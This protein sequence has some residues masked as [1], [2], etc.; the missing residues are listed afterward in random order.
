MFADAFYGCSKLTTIEGPLYSGTL[1]P[2]EGM[3]SRTFYNTQIT[4]VPA[5]VFGNLKGDGAPYMFADAFYGCSKLTTIEGPLYSGTLT[6]AES[7][8]YGTFRDSGITSVP[9]NVFG[10]LTGDGA[11]KMFRNT[12]DGCSKLTTIE[13][14]LFAGT[15]TPAEEM[16][17]Y[18]FIYT[19]ITSIPDGLFDGIVGAPAVRMFA[20]T[21]EDTPITSIPDG[22]FAGISG[23]PAEDMFS[24]TFQDTQITSIP[25]GLF[26]GVVGAP[27]VRMFE[28]TFSH[29]PIRSIPDGLFDGISGAPA[30]NM[31]AY[32][33]VNTPIASIPDGLFAGI[34]GAPA[35]SM[36]SGTFFSCEVLQ[37]I[38]ENL[39][40]DISG[41]A[42]QSMFKE[43]F[44]D[45]TSLTGPSARIGGKYLYEI[46]PDF[47]GDTY[48]LAT[49]LSD[50][51]QMPSGWK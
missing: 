8:F 13:G 26:D 41:P 44:A 24:S 43:T 22:L 9:T 15:L 48:F 51:Y 50:Y 34:S 29:T 16:F 33:F 14:P 1:T 32:T 45:C 37:S 28:S 31:F 27:A 18:T 3:F 30:E 12:F 49:G 10:N 39:F 6:P 21:F 46:W 23:A 40:G 36:F 2:A 25:D 17:A 47:S 19:P 38:P 4:S 11:P 20:S 7:M 5:N 42:A 35:E